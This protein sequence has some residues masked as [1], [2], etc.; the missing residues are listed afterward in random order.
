MGRQATEEVQGRDKPAAAE[1]WE[2]KDDATSD[3]HW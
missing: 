3:S 2:P 1:I